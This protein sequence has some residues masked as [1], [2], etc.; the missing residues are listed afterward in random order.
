MSYFGNNPKF[1]THDAFGRARTS[2]TG[3]RL[4]VEPLYDKQ[5]DY[6]DEIINGASASA[7]HNAN[8]RDIT[9][10]VGTTT[11][12][13]YAELRSHPVPY[14]PGNSQLIEMTGVLDLAGIG[15]GEA[16]AFVRTS[17]SGSAAETVTAQSSWAALTSGIDWTDSHILAMDFQSLKVGTIRYALVQ[18]GLP[19]QFLQVNNDNVRNSGY[20]QLASLPVYWKIYNDATYTYME[21]GYGNDDN[22]IG[23]RYRITANA[24]ATM[25]AICATVKSEGGLDLF[26]MPGIPR[27]ASNGVTEISAGGTAV[28]ILSI[29]PSSTFR[30]YDNLVLSLPKSVNVSS[31]GAIRVDIILNGSLTNDSFTPVGDSVMNYDVSATAISGGN[32]IYSTFLDA[33]SGPQA[34]AAVAGSI[35]GKV[36]M[37]N[38]Q[39][40]AAAITGILS[41]VAQATDAGTHSVLA[42]I[43]W[44]EIR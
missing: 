31:D 37:W 18:D 14:T 28:P 30:T 11:N 39:A 16:Q 15:G 17:I 4:D 10:T 21:M 36:I 23:I 29:T 2:G 12:G 27:S 7:T 43:N 35:L 25:K 9:L 1:P 22:A 38:R 42:A 32:V 33:A 20:W 34:A 13:E 40:S 24:T 44:E 6:L 5:T 26:N 41:V 3:Q 8:T 19:K